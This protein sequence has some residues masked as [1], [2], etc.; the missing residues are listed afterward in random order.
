MNSQV[1]QLV[2][3]CEDSVDHSTDGVG[4][5]FASSLPSA[6]SATLADP[7]VQDLMAADQVD[8]DNLEQVFGRIAAKLKNRDGATDRPPHTAE[9]PGLRR[10]PLASALL[11][12]LG[13]ACFAGWQLIDRKT[14][15]QATEPSAVPVTA[16]LA[17]VQDVPNY[18]EELGTVTPIDSVNLQ[19]R[20]TGQV[21]AIYFAP[22]QDVK[23]GQQLFLIDPRPYQAALDQA[24]AQLVHDQAA[25]K[26]AQMDLT[27]Y[28]TLQKQNSIAA[29]QPEDQV[30]VVQQDEGTV[31]LDQA[32]VEN[33]AL[34]LQY[35]Q[36]AAPI[37]GR[38]GALLVDVG[39]L[40]G[41]SNAETTNAPS[42]TTNTAGI[43]TTGN[44]QTTPTS[45]SSLVSIAQMQPI[46]V[47]FS[48]PQQYL[49]EVRRNQA[50][51]PLAVDAYSQSGELLETG[52]LTVIDNQVNDATGSVM[53]QAT[54]ANADEGLWPGEFMRV[55]LIVSTQHDAVTVPAPAVMAG[56][57]GSYAYVIGPQNSVH[58][59]DVEVARLQDGLAVIA[60]GIAGGEE[61]V[62]D[63][64]LRLA[65]NVKVAI[66]SGQQAPPQA[67]SG[68]SAD[69][70]LPAQKEKPTQSSA[71]KSRPPA[72][73]SS[74]QARNGQAQRSP[75]G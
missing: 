50:A 2:E 57:N 71:A 21:Q 16:T 15:A 64:Q 61:V 53:M 46:Y 58:R 12:L 27:R 17:K 20:V 4:G 51:A 30:Y 74:A 40:V 65:E 9:K 23:Q 26:Q 37:S 42:G 39:N 22:G 28:Q 11:A 29:Q 31:Q 19:S 35:C 70:G 1:C 60:K 66:Q 44:G 43:S 10:G 67:A 48:V 3:D 34:N 13:I 6:A 72:Q 14:P 68:Q 18:F 62:T 63:G 38:A 54:F 45:G 24:N 59:A 73:Q 8:R 5:A 41:G 52:K 56:P 69:A 33:A 55:R 49:D 32:A 47:N 25:L 7:I 36:I 75:A